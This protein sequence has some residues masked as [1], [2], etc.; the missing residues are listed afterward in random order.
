MKNEF[1]TMES[2]GL[3]KE[4]YDLKPSEGSPVL[5]VTRK[6]RQRA[7]DKRLMPIDQFPRELDEEEKASV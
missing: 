5:A 1:Q 2:S 7:A 6:R 3:L 4:V